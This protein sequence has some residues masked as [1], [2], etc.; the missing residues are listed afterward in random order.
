MM[1]LYNVVFYVVVTPPVTLLICVMSSLIVH[2][3]YKM[4]I[5]FNINISSTTLA[6]TIPSQKS[7]SKTIEREWLI[8]IK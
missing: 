7:N 3:K 6:M 2:T 5:Q 4:V 1:Q 8:L